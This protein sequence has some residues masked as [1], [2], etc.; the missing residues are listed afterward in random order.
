[1]WLDSAGVSVTEAAR[2]Q[3]TYAP[4]AKA[5][6]ARYDSAWSQRDTSAVSRLLAPRY[7]YFTSRGGVSSRAETM[8]MSS[9]PHYRLEHARRSEI[10]V[11]WSGPVVV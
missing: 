10:A 2:I 9:D 4:N 7:Q 8:A 6:V 11:S 5:Y 1:M 3:P